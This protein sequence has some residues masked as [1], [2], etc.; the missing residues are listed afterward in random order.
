MSTLP[1]VTFHSIDETGSVISVSPAVL[2]RIVC[3]LAAAG[4]RGCTLSEALAAYQSFRST[5]RLV[6]LT[7]DD[8][9]RNVATSGLP[10]LTKYGFNATVFVIAGRCGSD[11]QWPG[12][13]DWVPPQP[14]L[15]WE[16]LAAL[17]QAGWEIG[18]HGVEHVALPGLDPE[19]AARELE[20]A[21]QQLESTLATQVPLLA[22]PYG[23]HDAEIRELTRRFHSAAC[24]TRLALAS[25]ADVE[26]GFSLP[27]VD[28]YYLRRLSAPAVLGS[29]AGR[30]YL[31]ARRWARRLRH[32]GG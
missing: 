11:N 19:H 12:Q 32:G 22:Y 28:A 25:S 29:P 31:G 8:G 5:E 15:D 3:D 6:A 4:W 16:E 10:I 14:L 7:F 26:D 23:M 21:K 9:Y 20:D 24:G 30:A 13:A 1:I 27:R 18:S 17:Q 2:E